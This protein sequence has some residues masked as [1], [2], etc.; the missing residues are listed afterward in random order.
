MNNAR[1]VAALEGTIAQLT[2]IKDRLT[3]ADA[4]ISGT[5]VRKSTAKETLLKR[6]MTPEHKA[7]ISAAQKTRFSS[8]RSLANRCTARAL[9]YLCMTCIS[10]QLGVVSSRQQTQLEDDVFNF[11]AV[12]AVAGVKRHQWSQRES[13]ERCVKLGIVDSR[14]AELRSSSVF[15]FLSQ[16]GTFPISSPSDSKVTLL[17]ENFVHP[18]GGKPTLR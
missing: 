2:A 14:P 13:A 7:R 11:G 3:A 18:T 8:A 12:R 16:R 6:V 1:T 15:C 9:R 4:K 17:S 10:Q 5:P